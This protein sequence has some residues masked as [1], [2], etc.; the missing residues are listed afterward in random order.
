MDRLCKVGDIISYDRLIVVV[1]KPILSIGELPR[2]S[3]GWGV[4]GPQRWLVVKT[5]MTGG[6]SA[7]DGDY[8]DG[9]EVTVVPM[10]SVSGKP[11]EDCAA[12]QFFQSGPFTDIIEP[13]DITLEQEGEPPSPIQLAI[14][15]WS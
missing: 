11:R 10:S 8:P 2:K 7:H 3:S 5:D 14:K 6:G 15:A 1:Q 4:F 12:I 9:H 13:S